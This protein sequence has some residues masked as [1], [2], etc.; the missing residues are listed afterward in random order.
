VD[1]V[2]STDGLRLSSSSGTMSRRSWIQFGFLAAFWGASYLFI[3]VALEDVFEPPM[4]VFL[5]TALAAVVLVPFAL[6][7]GAL[8]ELRG[9]VG[10]VAFL[11]LLQVAA[12]FM[13]ISFGQEHISSSLAGILVATAPIFTF[14]LAIWI[15]QEERAHG[16]G[17][18]GVGLGIAG[19]VLLLGID[20]GGGAAALAGGLMVVLASLGYALGA[21]Y[22]KRK[23]S[24][25][26]P[27][28]IVAAT[29]AASAVIAAPV[30]AFS[31]PTAA[32]SLEAVA[33]LA[34]LGVFGTGISFVLFY[35]L[36][37]TVGPAK[38]SLVAYIAPGFAVVYGV[39]LLDESFT[40]ATASGLLLIVSGSWLAAEGRL[41]GQPKRAK[42][43]APA[44]AT[45]EAAR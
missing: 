32:P 37:A 6:R 2:I 24:G 33:S 35:S 30:A 31:L 38:A 5:R 16:V 1:I 26:E 27:V 4:I 28:A 11:A 41:P 36:I 25:I 9:Q 13:L 40:L 34:A 17:L 42:L 20:A 22:L 15:S 45:A 12:P 23:L 8:R 21:Y 19:V 18:V 14:L 10:V 3:K 29:M 43:G 39:V 7:S 44:A